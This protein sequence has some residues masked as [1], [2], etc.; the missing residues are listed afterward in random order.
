[1]GQLAVERRITKRRC[2]VLAF[3]SKRREGGGGREG[4]ESDIEKRMGDIRNVV[5]RYM[6]VTHPLNP[7]QAQTPFHTKPKRFLSPLVSERQR[8]FNYRGT[9]HAVHF[10]LRW[11]DFFSHH[12]F[13]FF[14]VSVFFVGYFLYRFTCF[15]CFGFLR[16]GLGWIV[17][18][19]RTT[20]N[21]KNSTLLVALIALL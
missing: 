16:L 18:C 1:M 19:R 12:L 6:M 14:S 10:Y 3:M 8:G 7:F 15:F 5:V 11:L 17:F 2:V 9:Y 4:R 13:Q 20:I 21:H